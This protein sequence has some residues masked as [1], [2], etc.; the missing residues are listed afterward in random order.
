M[1]A[2]DRTSAYPRVRE[3]DQE[4][5][6]IRQLQATLRQGGL[7]LLQPLALGDLR[8]IRADHP[9]LSSYRPT[10]LGL[11]VGNTRA[12]W[13]AFQR[14]L[15][16]LGVRSA[17]ELGPDP[18]DIYVEELVHGALAELADAFALRGAAV[19]SHE[20]VPTP[21][22][23]QRVA[24]IA[25]L[26]RI[27]PAHLSV[28]AKYG[29]WFALRALVALDVPAGVGASVEAEP[30]G[31]HPCETCPA[32]CR[33]ALSGALL[34][35]DRDRPAEGAPRAPASLSARQ[36]RWLGVRDACPIGH[37]HRYSDGQILY[38]YDGR[39]DALFRVDKPRS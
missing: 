27:G 25:G 8:E 22:P 24:E 15:R 39:R 18:L 16:G 7:D 26:A 35:R 20:L 30:S 32:P 19:F 36:K 3:G 29:P 37:S 14:H 33:Q 9:R 31:T 34:A 23:I 12:L 17:D 13:P 2:P 28:H 10:Q 21:I 5:Q 6:G 38:H 1:L 4:V 11:V